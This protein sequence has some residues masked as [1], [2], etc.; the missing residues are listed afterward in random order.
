MKLYRIE[1]KGKVLPPAVFGLL[2]I[3]SLKH[4]SLFSGNRGLPELLSIIVVVCLH[5]K[6]RQMLLSI[7]GGRSAICCWFS[8]FFSPNLNKILIYS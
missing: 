8:L 7:A 4:V 3:Y 1:K 5:L 2:V 6:K